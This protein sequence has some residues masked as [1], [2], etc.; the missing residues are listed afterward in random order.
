MAQPWAMAQ[1]EP[2]G[3]CKR[4]PRTHTE[5]GLGGPGLCAEHSTGCQ[6]SQSSMQAS[7]R[8]F[9]LASSRPTSTMSY[10]ITKAWA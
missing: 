1:R 10:L 9:P 5:N 6:D 8:R 4:A 2:G 3:A 7:P